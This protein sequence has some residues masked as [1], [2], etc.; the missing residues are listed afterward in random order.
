MLVH[1]FNNTENN[2]LSKLDFIYANCRDI[3]RR[4]GNLSHLVQTVF[5]L[6]FNIWN[7]VD[8]MPTESLT[9]SLFASESLKILKRHVKFQFRKIMQCD[10]NYQLR[11]WKNKIQCK[12]WF[13]PKFLIYMYTC[14][15]IC[16]IPIFPCNSSYFKHFFNYINFVTYLKLLVKKTYLELKNIYIFFSK[17]KMFF[18]HMLH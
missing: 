9:E 15:Y 14:I 6:M 2:I 13:F 3:R 11:H 18:F 5:N 4:C 17:K 8:I 1:K 10:Q 16:K 7:F 12:C